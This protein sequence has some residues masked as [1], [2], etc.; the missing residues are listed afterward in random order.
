MGFFNENTTY[1]GYKEDIPLICY[2][3]CVVLEGQEEYFI[4]F[5]A[6]TCLYFVWLGDAKTKPDLP[7][8]MLKV[9][10]HQAG[11]DGRPREK[12]GH[13]LSPHSARVMDVIHLCVIP[14]VANVNITQQS[15][16]LR[17]LIEDRA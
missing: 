4:F 10:L 16:Y 6:E 9:Y 13:Y 15:F 11:S 12:L 2:E 1:E 3:M 14:S 8:F 5:I 17:V 7:S